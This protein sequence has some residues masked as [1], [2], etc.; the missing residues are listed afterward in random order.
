MEGR[1]VNACKRKLGTAA[2]GAGIEAAP[3]DG[4]R[5]ASRIAAGLQCLPGGMIASCVGLALRSS[6]T[7]RVAVILAKISGGE[8]SGARGE[9]GVRNSAEGHLLEKSVQLVKR[10]LFL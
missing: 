7:G 10:E 9:K 2:G 3:P 1:L 4:H 5:A 6:M 8:N